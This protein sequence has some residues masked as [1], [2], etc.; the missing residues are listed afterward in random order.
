MK[1]LRKPSVLVWVESTITPSKSKKM[2]RRLGFGV[3]GF[4][5]DDESIFGK[6]VQEV[7]KLGVCVN[8]VVLNEALDKAHM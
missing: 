7:C 8:C 6:K 1:S 3:S 4:M 5:G 2:A